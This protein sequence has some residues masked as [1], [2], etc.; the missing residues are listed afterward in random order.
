MASAENITQSAKRESTMEST[1]QICS[2]RHS[3][4]LLFFQRK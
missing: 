3:Q 2:R 4:F 1:K